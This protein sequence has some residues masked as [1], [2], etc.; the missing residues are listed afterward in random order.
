[1]SSSKGEMAG[2]ESERG[3]ER[4]ERK[5]EGREVRVCFGEIVSE[6]CEEKFG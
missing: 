4:E 2:R 3:R 1:M 5:R 6:R